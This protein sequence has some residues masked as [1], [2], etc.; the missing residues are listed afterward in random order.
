MMFAVA[1]I[2]FSY[3][4]VMFAAFIFL[5]FMGKSMSLSSIPERPKFYYARKLKNK[6]RDLVELI[7]MLNESYIPPLLWGRSGHLQ[8]FFYGVLNRADHLN[9]PSQRHYI[10][11][12][13]GATVS[14]DVFEPTE[15][16][17]QGMESCFST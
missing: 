13:D 5:V 1:L 12:D 6:M 8:T 2:P 17:D 10:H 14:F 7:P 3:G 15:P 9:L 16:S 11:L 4:G